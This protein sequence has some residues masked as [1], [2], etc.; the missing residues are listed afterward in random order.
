MLSSNK[1]HT[2]AVKCV[3]MQ[4]FYGPSEV[5]LPFIYKRCTAGARTQDLTRGRGRASESVVC[6]SELKAAVTQDTSF[7]HWPVEFR[8][9]KNITEILVRNNS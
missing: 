4:K 3:C 6:D 5:N 8:V 9:V 7:S 2:E 1:G